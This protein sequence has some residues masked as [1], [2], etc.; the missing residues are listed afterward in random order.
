[1]RELLLLHTL[2]RYSGTVTSY[3]TLGKGFLTGHIKSP[4][5]F[6]ESDYRHLFPR[7]HPNNFDNNLK[8]VEGLTKLAESKGC[9]SGQIAIVWV[10]TISRTPGVPKIIPIP[11]AS[12]AARVQE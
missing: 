9:T 10:L 11:G 8:L 2:A 3:G 5:D 7:F 1:M 4:N 12:K 6:A